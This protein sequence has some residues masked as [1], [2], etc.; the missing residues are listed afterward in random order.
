V[1]FSSY[2]GRAAAALSALIVSTGITS[3]NADAATP[4]LAPV[5]LAQAQ[6]LPS[7]YPTDVTPVGIQRE[8][9]LFHPGPSYYLFQKLPQRMWFNL[10][11]ET[12]QRYESNVF[13]KSHPKASDYVFRVLPNITL[14]YNIAKNTSIYTNWFVIKDVFA[15]H[16][17]LSNPTDQSISMGIRQQVPMGTKSTLQF[18]FQARELFQVNHLHQFDFLPGVT[19]TRVVTPTTVAFGSIIMQMRGRDY[20]VAPTREIDP[21]YTIGALHS[22][23]RW[24]YTAVTTLVTNFRST[25]NGAVPPVSGNAIICDFEVSHPVTKKIPNLVAFTRAEPIWNFQSHDQPGI[26]GFDF[27]LYTGL[28]FNM[29]KPSYYNSVQKLREQLRDSGALPQGMQ[30]TGAPIPPPAS[31]PN[32]PQQQMNGA[33]GA[34]PLNVPGP[35]VAPIPSGAVPQDEPAVS[36]NSPLLPAGGLPVLGQVASTINTSPGTSQNEG[37]VLRGPSGMEFPCIPRPSEAAVVSPVLLG[38]PSSL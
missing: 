29:V 34:L 2:K 1:N 35:A 33:P 28:R 14:G 18:D 27:R 15:V 8:Q 17:R 22:H 7:L 30:P 23:G 21:F 20:F 6:P 37:P 11:A 10:T 32:A 5:T 38:N 4:N 24:V 13:F 26:S 19:Y 25:G 3:P 9:E 36:Q 31:D 16:G 12:S